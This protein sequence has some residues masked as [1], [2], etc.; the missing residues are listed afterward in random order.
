MFAKAGAVEVLEGF[1]GRGQVV[2]TPAIRD[3]IAIPLQYGYTFPQRVLSRIPVV[4][5]TEQAWQEHERLWTIGLSLG[6]GEL[7]AIA[8]CRAEGAFFATNDS[9]ARRFAQDQGV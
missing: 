9:A 2:M 5:L 7:E 8:L 4:R 3:E 1:L 6:K